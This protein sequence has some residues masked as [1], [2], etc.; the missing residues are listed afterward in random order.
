MR[1]LY[2]SRDYTP[3]DHRFLSALAET[4]H[5]VYYLRLERQNRPLE[6][7]PLPAQVQPVAWQGGQS[8]AGWRDYPRLLRGVRRVI[9][10]TK[11]D[12]IHAG[13]VQSAGFLAA[14]SGFRPLVTMSWGSDLLVD[15]DRSAWM[16][17]VTRYTLG[18]TTLMAGDCRAVQDKAA[19][20]GFP[21]ER[22]AL[23]P[24]GV[25]LQRFQPG[26]AAA[27][28]ARLGW[29]NAFVVLSLRT[30]EPLYGVDVVARG[31]A[32]AA[33]QRPQL[34]LLLLGGGSQAGLLRSILQQEGVLEQ[35]YLG[36]QINGD[37]LPLYY[38]AAD[39]YVSA[40]HSD[41]SSVSL[42]EA[43][44]SGL[45]ALVSDIPGNREW[46]TTGREGW[47]FPDGDDQSVTAG[48]LRAMDMGEALAEVRAAARALA[49]QRANWRMN[50][51]R[52]LAAYDLALSLQRAAG[53]PAAQS[54]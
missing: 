26:S 15:A 45:P 27:F 11:P 43:L 20:F 25:D 17:W 4:E 12:V 23:F 9:R 32:R 48:I 6:E 39:V 2:F 46:I 35:V 36:G 52:L 10:E 19:T 41:G 29:Q 33:R 53:K 1:V 8:P 22:V 24:W 49:E 51:Q 13:P 21:S 50:F 14:L 16:R 40:S 28:R 42:M 54:S 38:Q 7:R 3:H 5:S 18:R 44:A 34:R 31:F 30:W 47:I 37:E